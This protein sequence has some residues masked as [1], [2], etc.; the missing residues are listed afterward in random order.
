M[1]AGGIKIPI[2]RNGSLVQISQRVP[3]SRW[4]PR[5]PTAVRTAITHHN[6]SG[7][8][9]S[10]L[11]FSSGS[12]FAAGESGSVSSAAGISDSKPEPIQNLSG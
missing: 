11:E 7:G 12:A 9:T 6:K 10:R 1:L 4:M 2:D 5:Q 3:R 8:L